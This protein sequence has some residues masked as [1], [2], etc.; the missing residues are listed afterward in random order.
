MYQKLCEKQGL[1]VG[2]TGHWAI[3][4]PQ[5]LA[6]CMMLT[7]EDFDI[8]QKYVDDTIIVRII[9]SYFFVKY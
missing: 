6:K 7:Y 2:R 5:E 3:S 1:D 9:D 4:P 8:L